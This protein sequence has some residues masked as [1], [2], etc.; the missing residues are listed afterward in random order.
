MLRLIH[1]Q[2]RYPVLLLTQGQNSK[3]PDFRD[4]RCQMSM[5][6][7]LRRNPFRTWSLRQGVL[8][9]EM[10]G[11]LGVSAMAEALTRDPSQMQL[12]KER[13]QVIFCWTDEDN[14]K[15]TVL[16]LKNLGVD[17]VIYDRMDQNRTDA[18]FVAEGR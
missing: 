9:G 16:S 14:T 18:A 8:F 15:E 4:P 10:A 17:G 13:G 1:K 11:L 5:M 3:Y 2:N 12:V 7:H 6:C